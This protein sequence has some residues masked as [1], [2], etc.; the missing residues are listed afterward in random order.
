MDMERLE[1]LAKLLIE[2]K[3]NE[4]YAKDARIS[5]EESIAELIDTPE[6]GQKTITLDSKVKLTV[7]RGLIYTADIR[8]ISTEWH[9]KFTPHW[10]NTHPV[11]K[12][13]VV[14][15]E[16]DV[17]GYEWYRE[18]CPEAFAILSDQVFVKPKKT[19]VSIKVS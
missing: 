3:N 19:A 17:E 9:K 7:R 15:E 11:P 6:V 16:L 10:I 13:V 4:Q 12:T 8:A 1:T 14:K 18:N 2:T 5:I